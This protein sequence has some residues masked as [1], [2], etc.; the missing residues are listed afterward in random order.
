MKNIKE[1]SKN[2]IWYMI[3]YSNRKTLCI[4]INSKGEVIVR[5]PRSAGIERIKEFV[6]SKEKWITAHIEKMKC[7]EDPIESFTKED[8]NRFARE[9][10]PV[11][12][13][14]TAYFAKK[15]GVTYNRI[16]I[17]AQHTRFGSCSSNGNINYN[18]ILALFPPEVTDYVIIHE[19]AHRRHMDHSKTFWS[20]VAKY[21]PDYKKR[22]EW[23]K[24][25]GSIIIRRIP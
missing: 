15:M 13:E 12:S 16:T 22:V 1:I 17:R 23:L 19:L 10:A 5:V 11:L 14:R 7:A 24:T 21:C 4:Q 9:I 18:C 3:V 25:K 20:T 2:G 8:L 6:D